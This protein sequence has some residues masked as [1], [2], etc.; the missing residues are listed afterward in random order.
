MES[1]CAEMNT[2]QMKVHKRLFEVPLVLRFYLSSSVAE[3]IFENLLTPQATE[4]E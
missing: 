2:N 1:A 4:R 3:E